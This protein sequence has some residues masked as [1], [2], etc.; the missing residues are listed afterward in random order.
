MIK[1][2]LTGF[3]DLFIPGMDISYSR[4][5]AYRQCPYKYKLIYLDDWKSPP[6][7]FTSLGQS[8]HRALEEFHALKLYS[9]E[10]LL[11]CYNRSWKNEG[12]S[13]AVETQEFFDKGTKMLTNYFKEQEDSKTEILFIEKN[14]RF[15]L[16]RNYIIGIIDRVDKHPDGTYE[17]IDYKTH[18]QIWGKEKADSDLQLTIYSLACEK[19]LSF[20]ADTLSYYFLSHNKKVSTSRSKEQLEEAEKLIESVSR[21]IYKEKFEPDTSYCPKCDF[22]KKCKFSVFK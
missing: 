10:Q 11:D 13:S 19:A 18:Q 6:N 22:K 20:K 14:F 5:N 12:F 16:G 3:A 15:K 7:P 9:L 21:D 17:V 8:I 1:D 4:I 2:L